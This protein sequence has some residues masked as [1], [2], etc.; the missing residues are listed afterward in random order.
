MLSITASTLG[1]RIT[2]LLSNPVAYQELIGENHLGYGYLCACDLWEV[3]QPVTLAY[4]SDDSL[5]QCI[6]FWLSIFK[7]LQPSEERVA[8]LAQNLMVQFAGAKLQ[9]DKDQFIEERTRFAEELYARLPYMKRTREI[10]PEEQRELC[11]EVVQAS[12]YWYGHPSGKPVLA[13]RITERFKEGDWGWEIE[14][15]AKSFM[16]GYAVSVCLRLLDEFL[17]KYVSGEKMYWRGV[18]E[19][20]YDVVAGSVSDDAA[21]V[22]AEPYPTRGG[23]M[24]FGIQ[25]I[26][27]DSAVQR[28]IELSGLD[29]IIHEA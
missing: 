8:A 12:V 1:L 2:G 3:F 23:Y 13:P 15:G 4:M 21:G 19:S 7:P 28:I 18:L 17:N 11:E 22:A 16:V 24:V 14:L 9:E 29:G 26:H 6:D 10:T 27:L 20:I 25:A 5:R